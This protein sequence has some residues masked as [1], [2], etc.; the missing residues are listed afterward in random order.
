MVVAILASKLVIAGS[1][2]DVEGL[3]GDT[4]PNF[5]HMLLEEQ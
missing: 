3:F 2:A 4:K 1:P 5:Y